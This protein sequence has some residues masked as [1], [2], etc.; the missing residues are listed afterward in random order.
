MKIYINNQFKCHTTYSEGLRE[1]ECDFFD[2][3]CQTFIEGYRYIPLGETY[4]NEDGVE[5]NG[6]M[7]APFINIQI[8]LAAQNETFSF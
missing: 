4:T 6:E 8:L 1:I 3:K 5:F 7:V 2:G